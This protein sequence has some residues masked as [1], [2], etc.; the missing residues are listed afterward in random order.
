MAG[1]LDALAY[2]QEPLY[3]PINMVAGDD[4][5]MTIPLAFDVTA[6]TFAGGLLDSLG[7]TLIPLTIVKTQSTPTGILTV[8]LTGAQTATIPA[9]A[10]YFLRWTNA[11]PQVRTFQNGP[12]NAGLIV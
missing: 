10:V 8:S 11:T 6:Y 3:Q 4:L 12:F 9:G 5:I 1:P 7:R 2:N